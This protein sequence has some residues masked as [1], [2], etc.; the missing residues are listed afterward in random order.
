MW[1]HKKSE[2]SA[3][4]VVSNRRKLK[5]TLLHVILQ[6]VQPGGAIANQQGPIDA[7]SQLVRDLLLIP[8]DK[9]DLNVALNIIESVCKFSWPSKTLKNERYFTL[10]IFF[11]LYLF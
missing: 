6:L 10:S 1:L 7:Q 8:T 3:L 9:P 11:I 2:S 5:D 4:T